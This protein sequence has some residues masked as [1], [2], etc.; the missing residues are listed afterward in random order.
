M[1]SLFVLML[2]IPA[3]ASV[4]RAETC[5][6][7]KR[8][9]KAHC[10]KIDDHILLTNLVF[11]ADKNAYPFSYKEETLES[12]CIIFGGAGS[13]Y[14]DR[15]FDTDDVAAAHFVGGDFKGVADDW[16]LKTLSCVLP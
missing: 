13:K 6:S 12:L 2:M 3:I 16:P 10:E 15:T 11:K 14:T 4:A 7:T 8:E 1:K 9:V 5:K